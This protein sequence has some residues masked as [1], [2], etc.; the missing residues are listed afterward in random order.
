MNSI[1][2][3]VTVLMGGPDGE[4]DVSLASG[5]SVAAALVAAGFD[6]VI[7]HV[8][9]RKPLERIDDIPGDVLFPVLHG[10]WGEGGPLQLL[11]E[12]DGRPFIGCG[13]TA[14]AAAM[15]K[16]R[17]K[18]IARERSIPT[19]DWQHVHVGGACTLEPPLVIKP[20]AEGSSLNL[21]IAHT[22]AERD[23][24]IATLL[25]HGESAMA[26]TF[27]DGR[28]LTVGLIDGRPLTIIEI[29]PASGVY[30]YEAKYQRDDTQYVV[31]PDLEKD[32]EAML[33]RAAIEIYTGLNARHLARVDFLLASDGPW[34]LEV[35]T[36]PGFTQHSLLPKAA[37]ACGLP[38]PELCRS[39]VEMALRDISAG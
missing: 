38:M 2:P 31:G 25:S 28:E 39:L 29:K 22:V 36:M 11:L 16:H 13:A 24:A 9:E 17:T 34:L 33:K 27:V 15:D 7:E 26:E 30:D 12:E 6:Q 19:P 3:K 18:L 35:N 4:H 32:S 10:P 8:I 21:H 37:A 14:A 23:A 5:R 1:Q 20:V